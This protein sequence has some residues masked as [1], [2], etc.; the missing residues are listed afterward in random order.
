MWRRYLCWV[1]Y[2]GEAFCGWQAQP[3]SLSAQAAL[4]D[5]LAR[6]FGSGGFTKPVVASRTDAGVHAVANVVHFDARSRAKP[7]Q[8]ASPP[9]SAQRVAAALNAVTASSSPGL[10]VIGAVAVP[11][12]VSARFDAIGKTYVYRML[13]P[14]VPFGGKPQRPPAL[15]D[16]KAWCLPGPV[17]VPA[18]QEAAAALQGRHDFARLRGDPLESMLEPR[19]WLALDLVV[20]GSAFMYKQVRTMAAVVASAGLVGAGSVTHRPEQGRVSASDVRSLLDPSSGVAFQPSPAPAH[21]LYLRRV[22]L[23]PLDALCR[24]AAADD[25]RVGTALLRRQRAGVGPASEAELVWEHQRAAESARR[26]RRMVWGE[27][28]GRQIVEAAAQEGRPGGPL[29]GSAMLRAAGG[30]VPSAPAGACGQDSGSADALAAAALVV[31]RLRD[32]VEAASPARAAAPLGMPVQLV[33]EADGL[34]QPGQPL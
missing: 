3:G 26:I 1:Q 8:S 18:M 31:N 22:H 27:G 21:G 33:L 10:S 30:S 20:S 12:A 17:S 4:G 34:L 24:T 7:G 13:A 2:R 28:V 6:V 32:K 11:R 5:G 15:A 9:M 14:V 16:G 25:V 29:D 23:P 19:Q